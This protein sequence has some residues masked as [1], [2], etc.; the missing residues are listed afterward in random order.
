MLCH[1]LPPFPPV[2]FLTSLL[3]LKFHALQDT[4]QKLWN[5][6]GDPPLDCLMPRV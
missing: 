6:L 4:F 3:G 2:T 5:R 1:T